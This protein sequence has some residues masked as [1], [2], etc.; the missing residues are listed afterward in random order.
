MLNTIFAFLYRRIAKLHVRIWDH[1]DL[2][3]AHIVKYQLEHKVRTC[4]VFARNRQRRNAYRKRKYKFTEAKRNSKT[5]QVSEVV[6]THTTACCRYARHGTEKRPCTTIRQL[7]ITS[8]LE[9]YDWSV[10]LPISC[11]GQ[12]QPLTISEIESIFLCLCVLS[13]HR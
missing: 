3:S 11:V 9:F 12:K 8:M 5:K 6:Y 7:V 2:A 13:R 10:D 1:F 4:I